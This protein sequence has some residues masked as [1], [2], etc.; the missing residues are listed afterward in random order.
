MVIIPFVVIPTNIQR[1]V[2]N[3][4]GRYDDPKLGKLMVPQF[5]KSTPVVPVIRE[6]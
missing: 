1:L 2:W 3:F 4:F 6:D 5:P